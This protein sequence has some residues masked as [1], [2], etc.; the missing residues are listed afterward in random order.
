MKEQFEYGEEVMVRDHDTDEWQK[1]HYLMTAP[2]GKFRYFTVYPDTRL[3]GFRISQFA[4]YPFAQIRK[5]QKDI[6]TMTDYENDIWA[7]I[8]HGDKEYQFRFGRLGSSETILETK[9]TPSQLLQIIQY[10]GLDFYEHPNTTD[11][12]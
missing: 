9:L 10:S 5:I 6:T 11:N 8:I 4:V 1:R 3:D 7:S 2:E 12:D